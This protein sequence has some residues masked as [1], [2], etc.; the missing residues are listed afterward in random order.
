MSDAAKKLIDKVDLMNVH[1]ARGKTYTFIECMVV[2]NQLTNAL[3]SQL[4]LATNTREQVK[5]ETAKELSEL[6]RNGKWKSEGARLICWEYA[7]LLPQA[8][9][10]KDNE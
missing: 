10:G 3:E 5:A 4:S 7:Q 8:I 2:M 9:E 1:A 6:F